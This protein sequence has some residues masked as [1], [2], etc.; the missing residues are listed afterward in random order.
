MWLFRTFCLIVIGNKA[1]NCSWNNKLLMKKLFED[2]KYN[3]QVRPVLDT[4]TVINMTMLLYVAQVLDMDE[5]RQTLKTNLWMTL[6]WRDEY[7]QWDPEDF[8]NL[9]MIKIPSNLVWMPDIVLYDNADTAYLPFLRDKIIVLYHNGTC[10][11]ASP[12]I[13]KS[14]CRL[15]VM[16]F[17][18]DEQS[19][20][21]K[22]G[23]WQHD[24]TEIVMLG[25][26]DDSVFNSDGEWDMIGMN[27]SSNIQSYPDAPGIPYTDVVYTLF[28]RRRSMYYVFNLV[29]PC[30]LISSTT[31]LCFLL[32]VDSGEKISLTITVLL[33]LT[34][35]LLL[36]AESMPPS[37]EVPIIG[38]YYAATMLLVSI[39][40]A[41]TI[42]VLNLHYRGP[43]YSRVPK[44]AK[45]FFLKYLA[46]VVCIRI[47]KVTSASRDSFLRNSDISDESGS[48]MEMVLLDGQLEGSPINGLRKL[49]KN[50]SKLS[51]CCSEH[52]ALLRMLLQEV[53]KVT[54][55]FEQ[56][57]TDEHMRNE[58]KQIAMVMDRVFMIIYLCCTFM[59]MWLIMNKIPQSSS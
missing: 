46:K 58:W 14:H 56:E 8:G 23:P 38:K 53:K 41:M 2:D 49:K 42:I 51:P 48:L 17:P 54:R 52:V 28:F 3:N 9:K 24:G 22:F 50:I 44:W 1:V 27:A 5:R 37:S 29:L 57:D 4:S 26:G 31:V 36:I 7:L 13:V 21:M 40:M 35:F 43:M 16:N 6:N 55:R 30:I 12:I 11:W 39:S 10:N 45:I 15:N 34:V 33:S 25:Q 18:F 20:K 47:P 19:C 59:T 32:P